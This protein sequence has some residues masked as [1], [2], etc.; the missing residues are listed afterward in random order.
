MKQPV[1][2]QLA[3]LAEQPEMVERSVAYVVRY[4]RKFLKENEKVLSCFPL[5]DTASCRILQ[6]SVEACG[7]EMVWIGEDRRWITILKLAFTSKCNCIIGPPLMLLG[8]SK[9]AKHMGTPLFARNILLSGYSSPQWIVEAV[10]VGLD[11]KAW[12]CYDPG[13]GPV[14]AGFTCGCKDGL[15]IRD[16]VY[17]VEIVDKEDRPLPAGEIGRVALYPLQDPSLRFV[18]DNL[19]ALETAPCSCGESSPRLVKLDME[20]YDDE[21]LSQMGEKLLYWSSVLDCRLERTEC[22]LELEVVIFQGEKLPKFPSCAK[23]II[24][25]WNPETDEPFD[26]GGQMKKKLISNFSD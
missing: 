10:Q 4:M 19:G 18:T 16:D 20:K 7:C 15:H 26:H 8:L 9:V 14:I 2:L 17:G 12:G 5:E 3:Q 25:P 1:F 6:R 23:L 21:S 22:G 11:C 13:I 24:R